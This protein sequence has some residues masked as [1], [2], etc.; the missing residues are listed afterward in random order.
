MTEAEYDE[1]VAPALAE[2]ARKVEAM[3]GSLI[4]RV[5]WQPGESGI[6]QI[7]PMT[8]AGQWMTQYAAHSHG[9]IDAMVM[10]ILR[11]GFD[12]SQ[13]LVLSRYAQQ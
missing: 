7:G 1:I 12:V 6:T 8:S 9:N 4:A 2:I 3:G 10:N 11:A 13:S 5:E